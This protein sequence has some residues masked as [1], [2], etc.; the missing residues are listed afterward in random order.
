MK[1]WNSRILQGIY[2]LLLLQRYNF[3]VCEQYITT[4]G[5]Y[6]VSFGTLTKAESEYRIMDL[7]VII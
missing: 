3:I 6:S 5:G 2:V 4:Y 1:H 7:Q